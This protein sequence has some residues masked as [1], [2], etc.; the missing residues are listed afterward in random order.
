MITLA[1]D[2]GQRGAVAAVRL[3][4]LGRLEAVA[5]AHAGGRGG[6]QAGERHLA[7]LQAW[8]A[9][10]DV[11]GRVGQ[12]MAPGAALWALEAL[13]LRAG[14][15]VASTATTAR[16]WSVWWSVLHLSLGPGCG[17]RASSSGHLKTHMRMHTGERPY[18]CK[19]PG[20]GYSASSSG[21][22][23]AHLRTHTGERPFPC[24]VPGCG[25]KAAD[26][27]TLVRHLRT[28]S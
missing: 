13:G 15:G 11:L 8:A 5:I 3:S 12:P 10:E 25:Y 7:P 19:V 26:S 28:H 9:V 1:I 27:S 14:E 23:K 16:G 20:C 22:L 17:Y 24:E 21:H 4:S 6:Y 18:P 2:P